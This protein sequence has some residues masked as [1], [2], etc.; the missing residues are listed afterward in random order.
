M[1]SPVSN[2]S[3]V[4]RSETIEL[5]FGCGIFLNSAK[6]T[7]VTVFI[8]FLALVMAVCDSLNRCVKGFA[9]MLS[10]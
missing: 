9:R 8:E 2:L 7:L 5:S 6:E 4:L 3:L 10:H 1:S